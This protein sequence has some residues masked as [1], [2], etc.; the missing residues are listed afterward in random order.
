MGMFKK[1]FLVFANSALLAVASLALSFVG[2][3]WGPCAPG[4]FL[5]I[6]LTLTGMVAGGTAAGAFI[7]MGAYWL[8][9]ARHSPARHSTAGDTQ[10]RN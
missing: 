7:G 5:A 2:G 6:L 4:S 10:N 1:L 8:F 3:G 9:E